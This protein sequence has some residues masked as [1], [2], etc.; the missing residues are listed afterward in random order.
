MRVFRIAKRDAGRA[1]WAEKKQAGG[2]GP[3]NERREAIK[4]KDAEMMSMFQNM[5]KQ[6]F[7]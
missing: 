4:A 3:S 5:A 7:G 6:R 1:R 2:A